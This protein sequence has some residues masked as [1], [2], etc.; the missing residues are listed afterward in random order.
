MKFIKKDSC[1]YYLV[2]NNNK[3]IIGFDLD[4][5][6]IKTKSGAKFPKSFDDWIYQYDNINSELNSEIACKIGLNIGSIIH[7]GLF[8]KIE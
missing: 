7:S 2:K 8:E 5:T 4:S 1:Y 3:K 6:L